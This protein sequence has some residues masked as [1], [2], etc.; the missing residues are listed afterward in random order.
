M[1]IYLER[2]LHIAI[3]A[4]RWTCILSAFILSLQYSA[5]AAFK[6]SS[7]H[8]KSQNLHA[9]LQLFTKRTGTYDTVVCRQP[10]RNS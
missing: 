10:N 8:C 6:N 1:C 3:D 4:E 7:S 2:G 5:H 9:L